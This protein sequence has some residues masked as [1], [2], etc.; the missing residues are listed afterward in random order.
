MAD[1][2]ST[3]TYSARC[4]VSSTGS[5]TVL[6]HGN[7]RGAATF[8]NER[9]TRNDVCTHLAD[10]TRGLPMTPRGVSMPMGYH[11]AGVHARYECIQ[12]LHLVDE[13]SP[14]AYT[15]SRPRARQIPPT[16]VP[17]ALVEL[18]RAISRSQ[19]PPDTLPTQPRLIV[20]PY[21]PPP[22]TVICCLLIDFSVLSGL[23][24]I[25][26]PDFSPSFAATATDFAQNQRS[27]LTLKEMKLSDATTELYR[28]VCRMF[29]N[30]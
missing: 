5:G 6:E 16:S 9:D 15:I 27:P 22:F 24:F 1:S 14:L 3:A 20:N 2:P 29:N 11:V 12:V 19:S 13:C 4:R 7:P 26:S 8:A 23:A 25:E 28:W 17:F 18:S 30:R 10:V 21:R